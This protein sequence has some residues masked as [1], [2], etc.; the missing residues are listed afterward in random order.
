[1]DFNTETIAYPSSNG[2]AIVSAKLFFPAE[3]DV[4]AIV[5]ISHGM[6][7]YIDRYRDF[8][9]FLCAKG[10]LVCGNDHIGHRHSVA[11]AS[12]LGFFA[13]QGGDHFLVRDVHELTTQMRERFPDTPCFLLG[14][15][16][17]SFVARCCLAEFGGEYDGALISGTGG[18]NPLAGSGQLLAE[19]LCKT[20]GAKK[21]GKLLDNLAFGG[22]NKRFEHRTDKDWLTR[23][24]TVVDAYLADPFCSF[25]FTNAG[26]RDLF[27]LTALCNAPAWA[28]SLPRDL[29]VLLFSGEDD[30]VGDYGAGVRKVYES[31]K[32]AGM[33]DVTLKL[34]KSG[35]HEML[36][37]INHTEVYTDV[38]DWLKRKI[39]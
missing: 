11:D 22:Y 13:E 20:G 26:F 1:M 14:H 39:V 9:E 31:M 25:R 23:D 37:E 5:Q 3:A 18:P 6:C 27:A 8:A 38:Y 10:F 29:P 28:A 33:S 4:K 34:Y 17:G 21:R 35:R 12:Q 32:A 36:N 19:M 15:S 16:M 30:P 24:K 2:T 7:E